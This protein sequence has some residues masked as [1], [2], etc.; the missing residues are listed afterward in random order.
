MPMQ[1]LMDIPAPE[2]LIGLTY[3]DAW[4][5]AGG[6]LM[7]RAESGD[8][9]DVLASLE[10][11]KSEII[12]T[13]ADARDILLL[14]GC[15]E[16]NT[17][18]LRQ[19]NDPLG[20]GSFLFPIPIYED[21]KE[22]QGFFARLGQNHPWIYKGLVIAAIV[23]TVGLAG[24]LGA[25]PAKKADDLKGGGPQ[26][27]F[28]NM[29]YID[30]TGPG[31]LRII[32]VDFSSV[33]NVSNALFFHDKQVGTSM[34]RLDRD[35]S[36]AFGVTID[37]SAYAAY[38]PVMNST[39]QYDSI[40]TRITGD[41]GT[42]ELIIP[43]FPKIISFERLIVYW[44]RETAQAKEKVFADVDLM[45]ANDTLEQNGY[46]ANHTFSIKRNGVLIDTKR[47]PSLTLKSTL[48]GTAYFDSKNKI[49]RDNNV[50][51]FSDDLVIRGEGKTYT[52][53]FAS[54]FVPAKLCGD[55]CY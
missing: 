9:E 42:T 44:G 50:Y 36:N 8:L 5:M 19:L 37:H 23:G 27:K 6:A 2:E 52:G 26:I 11:K 25:A 48:S 20:R 47:I 21:K 32:P 38:L 24:C 15:Y 22:Q 53:R 12:G 3:Y 40:H 13:A 33:H 39:L 30:G 49:P 55:G 17:I 10:F 54:A 43:I 16:P 51:I 45:L 18:H 46:L 35:V 28:A 4:R 31:E 7:R 1:N 29:N 14:A 41:G 34:V